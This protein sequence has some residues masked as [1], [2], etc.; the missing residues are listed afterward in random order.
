MDL[1]LFLK[2][3]EQFQMNSKE[4][5]EREKACKEKERTKKK[6]RMI[7]TEGEYNW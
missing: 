6:K 5:K 7:K 2:I 1:K 3:F 4:K